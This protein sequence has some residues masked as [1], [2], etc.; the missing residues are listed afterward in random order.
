MPPTS[1]TH[2]NKK[3]LTDIMQQ[4]GQP[5]FRANQIFRW[6]YHDGVTDFDKMT[7][8]SK[9]QRLLY[10]EYFTLQRPHIISHQ[11]SCDG[12]QKLL[13]EFEDGNQAETV[14]IPEKTRGTLCVSSQ[15]GCTL[16]CRFCHTGTQRMVRNLTMGEIIAQVMIMKD[17]LQDWP[18]DLPDRSI[19]NI[20]FMGMGEPLYNTNHVIESIKLMNDNHGLGISK[21][22]ITVSTSGIIP[23]IHKIGEQTG[24]GLAIS[25]H[26]V[27][28]ELRN[29]LVP[30][31]KKY[32]LEDLHECV[33]NYPHLSNVHR[34]TWEYV[35]LDQVNDSLDDAKK[36]I[37]Y[38]GDI[39]SKIN[40]IPFN[41]WPNAPYKTSRPDAIDQ[42]SQYILKA[43]Y[44]S[45]VRK[46]RGQ[47]ILAAC[48]QLKSE[49]VK[50]AK[51]LQKP[52]A[53]L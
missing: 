47:D 29:I 22:R 33:K 49:S 15:V 42:F 4:H 52:V 30:I 41:P 20:V 3:Q 36:L 10:K 11:I 38:I 50:Q 45:P 48:G 39:P 43:G 1:I 25:L 14:Y 24:A 19:T 35:M 26:A 28:N 21:R 23:D 13:L 17:I 44:A 7:N 9:P 12:T 6:V 51:S 31:N 53:S 37:D 16:N 32:P 18:S 5:A 34:I 27:S 40:L 8:I 46:P 2:Y